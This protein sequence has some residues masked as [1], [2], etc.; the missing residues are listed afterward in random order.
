[1]LMSIKNNIP[2]GLTLL[3]LLSGCLGIYFILNMQ[4]DLVPYCVAISLV[5]DFLDGLVA[6]AINAKTVIG[7]DLDS[8]ADVVSF[9]VLPGA[10]FFMLLKQYYEF[11][12]SQ[13]WKL[14][15]LSLPGFFVTLFAAL[16]LAKFNNDTRQSDSFIGLATPASTMFVVGILLI[17]LKNPFGLTSVFHNGILL[18]TIITALCFL[19]ISEIPMFSFKLKGFSFSKSKF[20]IIFLVGVIILLFT[21]KFAA[22]A[23]GVVWYVLLSIVQS[24]WEK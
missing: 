18:Y 16:R 13:D 19:Q 24:K 23:A 2:N 22:V 17:I 11:Q 1:M 21:L 7:K 20:Q 14:I 5:A 3:N 6:R 15:L 12:V 8:L 10:I 4:Y 9:G